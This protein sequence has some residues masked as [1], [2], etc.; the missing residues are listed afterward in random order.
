MD[1]ELALL[2]DN[3]L[4]GNLSSEEVIF[5]ERR[6]KEDEA[7]ATQYDTYKGL[8][9]HF[10]HRFSE[11]RQALKATIASVDKQ[12]QYTTSSSN[13]ASKV[14]K[15]SFIKY[16]IAASVAVIIGMTLFLQTGRPSYDEYAFRGTINLVERG[17]EDSA[18][19]KAEKAFNTADYKEAIRAFD[20]IL[21]RGENAEIAYYKGIALVELDTYEEAF[22]IFERLANGTSIYKYEAQFYMALG[23]LKQ[24]KREKAHTALKK[25]PEESAI[26]S[27]AKELIEK[28]D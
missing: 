15:L 22:L 11:N 28:L 1:D 26:Y 18:F 6:L 2:F 3:Y 25:I 27:K 21:E 24:D 4:S 8:T 9:A 16:A 17:D 13:T 20:S 12:Y 19:A 5:F 23:Y 14:R 10:E 7:F